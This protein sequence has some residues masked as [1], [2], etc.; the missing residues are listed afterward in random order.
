MAT[1]IPFREA[2][3]TPRLNRSSQ[4]RSGS[5]GTSGPVVRRL[6]ASNGWATSAPPTSDQQK[7]AGQD[8]V[9]ATPMTLDRS[10]ESSD[11]A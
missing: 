6:R 7:T 3:K 11:A 2:E 5:S 9:E 8:D 10:F 1:R 4:R